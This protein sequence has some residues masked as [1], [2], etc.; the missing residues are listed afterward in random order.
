[1]S[2][3]TAIQF[4]V[5]NMGRPQLVFLSMLLILSVPGTDLDAATIRVP[6]DFGS[7]QEAVDRAAPGDVVIVEEGEYRENVVIKKPVDLRG[8]GGPGRP[9]WRPRERKSRYSGWRIRK[10]SLSPASPPGALRWPG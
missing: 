1:M 5:F 6:G 7:I 8:A 4:M 3:N 2:R 9:W 10:M